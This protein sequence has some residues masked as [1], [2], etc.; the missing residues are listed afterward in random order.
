M[1]HASRLRR[2]PQ[3]PATHRADT[4]LQDWAPQ[5]PTHLFFLRIIRL[6]AICGVNDARAASMLMGQFGRNHRRPLVL[7]RAMMLEL[8]RV[9]NRQI[10]LA[11]PC[12]GRMTRDEALILT[13]L[14]RPEAEFAACH[15]D[16]CTL[17]DREDAL[18][19]T[20]CLQAVSACFADL[21]APL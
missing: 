13:A 8:S 18:G 7:M 1:F 20:T 5:Q 17:L 19:A 16:A 4:G 9:S 12:C 21:G 15:G 14:G 2:S 10:K 6:M 3:T 11:P